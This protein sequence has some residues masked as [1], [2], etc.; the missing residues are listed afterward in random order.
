MAAK[1]E[2][3]KSTDQTPVDTVPDTAFP[4]IGMGASA[5]G[6]EAFEQFFRHVPPN[7][8]M[9]FVLMQHLDPSHSSILSQILQR[10]ATITSGRG[11]RSNGRR[12]QQYLCDST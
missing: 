7:C 11:A 12:T 8:G 5:G 2:T 4:I 3:K 9:A 10:T 6:L 1:K